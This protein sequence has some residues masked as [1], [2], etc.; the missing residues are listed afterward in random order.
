MRDDLRRDPDL[1]KRGL[2]RLGDLGERCA[3]EC[4]ELNLEAVAMA[5]LLEQLTCRVEAKRERCLGVGRPQSRRPEAPVDHVLPGEEGVG[6]AVVVDRI[7]DR[8]GHLRFPEDRMGHIGSE[9]DDQ[10]L[11][12]AVDLDVGAAHDALDQAGREIG[13]DIDVAL[14]EEQAGA[15]EE[16][17]ARRIVSAWYCDLTTSRMRLPGTP[18]TPSQP[19]WETLR[20][21]AEGPARQTRT[22]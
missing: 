17:V 11:R 14:L 10:R 20:T 3:G 21:A 1:G 19:A 9:I 5:R 2:D 4:I 22:R 7:T 18:S 13:S 6:H 16:E 8:F 15:E 12:I